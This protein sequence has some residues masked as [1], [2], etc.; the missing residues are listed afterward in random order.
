MHRPPRR[1]R[2]LEPA[3]LDLR[4]RPL[5]MLLLCVLLLVRRGRGGLRVRLLL[6]RLVV[7]PCG[8]GVLLRLVGLGLRAAL[9]ALL[10]LLAEVGQR[11]RGRVRVPLAGSQ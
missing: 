1:P 4:R 9:A 7:V 6:P 5:A 10:A 8:G 11:H 3:G 2:P